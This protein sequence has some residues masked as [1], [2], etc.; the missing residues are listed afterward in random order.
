MTWCVVPRPRFEGHVQKFGSFSR[1]SLLCL[2]SL[3]GRFF[4]SL[5]QVQMRATGLLKTP[6]SQ[7][8]ALFNRPRVALPQPSG[9]V[10]LRCSGDKLRPSRLCLR[11]NTLKNPLSIHDIYPLVRVLSPA[12]YYHV[13]LTPPS[14]TR[15]RSCR[16][17]VQYE[18]SSPQYDLQTT[19]D[20]SG[21]KDL[22]ERLYYV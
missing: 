19:P 15:L 5:D 2:R 9:G 21:S 12:H 13:S 7:Q 11:T 3:W 18:L 1:N 20:V 6:V 8:N 22:L 10:L 17:S 4:L 14:R 16:P